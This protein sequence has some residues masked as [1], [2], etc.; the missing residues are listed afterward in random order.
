MSTP[1]MPRTPRPTRALGRWFEDLPVGTRVEH[2]LTRTVSEADNLLFSTMT[3]NPQP[4]HVDAHFAAETE[5]GRPL[6]N[7]LFTLGTVVGITVLEL[8]HG[9]TVANLGFDRITFPHPVF[10][11][12][13]LH[14]VS[15]VT[16][17]RASTSR[18]DAGVV[19]VRHDGFNQDGVLVCSAARAALMRRRP[20]G[21]DA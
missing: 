7:S 10:H 11:G 18:P 2:A 17:A 4:L 3:L 19:H 12:D 14:A 8:T 20:T 16:A 5:F 21:Q 13:T 15:E 9:T 6:V 1:R